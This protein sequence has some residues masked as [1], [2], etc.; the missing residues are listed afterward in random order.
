M[1]YKGKQISQQARPE[2]KDMVHRV[3]CLIN[4]LPCDT[5]ANEKRHGYAVRIN[6]SVDRHS[7]RYILEHMSREVIRQ[8]GR[9]RIVKS[10][11][12]YDLQHCDMSKG[13][14]LKSYDKTFFSG[15]NTFP[16]MI[17]DTVA[18]DGEGMDQA[19]KLGGRGVMVGKKYKSHET[20][21]NVAE[22]RTLLA[23]FFDHL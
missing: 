9:Y 15:I 12:Y 13:E 3:R 19:A 4:E 14:A 16:V 6:N 8:H 23:W 10:T 7:N 5:H 22:V 17:G 2:I 1:V 21:E 18:T 20:L 11:G